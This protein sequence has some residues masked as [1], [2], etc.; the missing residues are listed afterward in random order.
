MDCPSCSAVEAIVDGRCRWCQA[1]VARPCPK[2]R[3]FVPTGENFCTAC[4][5]EMK[6]RRR[7][8]AE[9]R[10]R[11]EIRQ[12]IGRARR[13]LLTMAILTLVAAIAFFAI[14]RSEVEK[15][16]QSAEAQ[17]RT[18]TPEQRDAAAKKALGLTWDEAMARDR[19]NVV[20]LFA[21]NVALAAIYGGLWYWAKRNALA[22]SL[23]AL[24]LYITVTVVSLVLSPETMMQGLAQG[25]IVR[26][27]FVGVLL[28]AVLSAVKERKLY[29]ARS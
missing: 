29:G 26:V 15:Q 6:N 19:R 22:A 16:I 17:T 24:T 27:V 23:V 18:L 1:V 9:K 14:G 3:A 20:L 5:T 25:W 8:L 13:W 21:V 12:K 7:L 10:D 28:R 2:C 11:A 4:G